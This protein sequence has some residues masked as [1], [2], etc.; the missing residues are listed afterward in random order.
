MFYFSDLYTKV[1]NV[2]ST[3]STGLMRDLS[4]CSCGNLHN[5]IHPQQVLELRVD[6]MGLRSDLI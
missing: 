1:E 2:Y 6:L 3:E 5:F 4:W